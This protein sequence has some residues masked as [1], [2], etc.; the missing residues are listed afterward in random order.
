LRNNKHPSKSFHS[1]HKSKP[2][3]AIVGNP[4]CGKTALFNRLTGLH[5]RVGNYPGITVEKKSGLL[6]GSGI[7]I[8]DFPG[9]YSLKARSIDERIVAEMVQSWRDKENRPRGVI[10]V[11]DSTN[12]SRNI[13]L[14]LQVLDW[15]VPTIVVL[16]M[17]DEARRKGITIDIDEIKSRLNAWA[18]I[19]ASAKYGEG[20]NELIQ[21]VK[22]VPDNAE[23]PEV[24][25]RL[26]EIEHHKKIISPLVSFLR[27]EEKVINHN[28]HVEALRLLSEI[29]YIN[30]LKDYLPPEKLNELKRILKQVMNVFKEKNIPYKALE[31]SSRFGFIDLYLSQAVTRDSIK[32]RSRSEKADIFI[33]HKFFGPVL[34]VLLFGFIFTAIF[35]WAEYP[36]EM[37]QSVIDWISVR[38]GAL[39]PDG[40]LKSLIING[41]ISGAGSILVFLPQI[42]LLVFFLG[43]LEDSGY[44]ARMA[45]MLDKL[46]HK[47]GLH[48]R[49]VLPL[50]SGFAC[51]IPAVMASRTIEN[52]R[53][54]LVTIMMIPLMSCSA[55]LPIYVLLIAA[56]VPQKIIL[57][58][59]HLQGA[60][61]MGIYF[62]GMFTA[63]IVA[64]IFK[65][66]RPSNSV[67]SMMI[68]LPPYRRPMF[69][70][71]MWQLY[72]RSK[73]FLFTAGSIILA[74]SIVL[75][76][77]ASY[78]RPENAGQ[79]SHAELMKQSYA[80][81]I[82]HAI[83]P[84]IEPLG[85]NW[86]IGVG[87][88][89][90]FAAR[91]VIITT[92]ATLYNLED[93]SG[94]NRRLMKAMQKDRK[95]DGTP[96]FPVLT[97]LSLMVYFAY[98]AQCIATF[99]IIKKETNT[100]RW[101][102]FMVFYMTVL[103]YSA[104]FIF[105]QGGRLLGY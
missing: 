92:L 94:E 105:Y 67:H 28:A 8:R 30:Y 46:M 34:M 6:K 76:F 101:P 84:V 83:E 52:R 1:S 14:A 21:A 42:L 35:S 9:T 38:A 60:A 89:T 102:F 51:A 65:K 12:F 50:L 77:L 39:L 41:I 54:R 31:Q 23:L 16:N 18:V 86:K 72:D 58:F 62:L 7:L 36:M 68:E 33:T 79:I 61:L 37:I 93:D 96:V 27:N 78:P 13:Y 56:F 25:P 71:I 20:I 99:A 70:S 98:A 59:I 10:V 81:R 69:S 2:W 90:T 4:N 32:K 74:V 103:A 64:L 26:V 15:N 63:I 104:S 45:F 66:V 85:F 97:A 100:W 11:V 5:Q 55:R 48:G 22:S 29:N 82:G 53:D 88:I 43:I 75:W 80:G 40:Q 95:P 57:G 73:S 17:I 49:S 87:L 19:P 44:M 91:E 3:I 24:E 47:I